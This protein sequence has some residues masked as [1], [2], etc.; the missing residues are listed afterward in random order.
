[1]FTSRIWQTRCRAKNG[2][3]L[4]GTRNPAGFQPALGEEHASLELQAGL[5]LTKRWENARQCS[6]WGLCCHQRQVLLFIHPFPI[7]HRQTP[8]APSD[9]AATFPLGRCLDSISSSCPRE[10][11][12]LVQ[13]QVPKGCL[14]VRVLR[15]SNEP[16]SRA[17]HHAP[18]D[19][20]QLQ[21]RTRLCTER[22]NWTFNAKCD[23]SFR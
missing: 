20:R 22:D 3:H 13:V 14:F 1:M 11:V 10:G 18:C 4:P 9:P 8:P 7:N 2:D 6:L 12:V 17:S 19:T 21:T 23:F 5:A 16:K 15:F